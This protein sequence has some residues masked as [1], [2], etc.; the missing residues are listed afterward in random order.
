VEAA[1]KEIRSAPNR[2]TSRSTNAGSRSAAVPTTA[3]AGS[4]IQHGD[5]G[6]FVPQP[7]GDL[8]RDRLPHRRH[9]PR[10][11]VRL[12]PRPVPRPVQIHDVDPA[13]T[14]RREA[15]RHLAGIGAVDGLPREVAFGQPYHAPAAQ[16]DGGQQL[17]AIRRLRLR[18]L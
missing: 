10:H 6:L 1:H 11:A 14:G 18:A 7:A 4:G 12:P 16:I 13:R 15:A 3:R 5:R 9:D 2:A 8:A 17:E